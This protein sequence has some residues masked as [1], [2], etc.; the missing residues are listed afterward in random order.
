VRRAASGISNV[1]SPASSSPTDSWSDRV[2]S[3]AT[4]AISTVTGENGKITGHLGTGAAAGIGVGV[5]IAALILIVVMVV[6]FRRRRI[7]LGVHDETI[8]A[9]QTSQVHGSSMSEQ[10][11]MPWSEYQ[12]QQQK[13]KQQQ[14]Q[15]ETVG[16][17]LIVER[18]N[19]Y[20]LNS[21][22]D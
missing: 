12:Q 11:Y 18:E 8:S 22:R 21:E 5:G 6:L 2:T 13:P 7:R 17:E 14:E 9:E 1:T 16:H 3:T 10:G 19:V 4:A 15:P 20:E